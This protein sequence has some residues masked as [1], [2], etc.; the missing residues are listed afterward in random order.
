MEPRENPDLLTGL[1]AFE[2]VVELGQDLETGVG[3]TQ[4]SLT[5][6][7]QTVLES[8][9]DVADRRDVEG[10]GEYKGT[11]CGMRKCSKT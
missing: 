2:A 4:P 7:V 1:H 3:G 9:V 10:H 11:E 8:G 5:R 6:R